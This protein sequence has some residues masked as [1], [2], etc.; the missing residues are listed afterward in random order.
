MSSSEAQSNDFDN[1][2]ESA[3]NDETYRSTSLRADE[4]ATSSADAVAAAPVQGD[5]RPLSLKNRC[6]WWNQIF[7][8]F[9][10][11]LLIIFTFFLYHKNKVDA[12]T[13]HMDV[14]TLTLMVLSILLGAILLLRS[15][16]GARFFHFNMSSRPVLVLLYLV[17]AIVLFTDAKHLPSWIMKLQFERKEVLPLCFLVFAAMEVLLFCFLRHCY[18]SELEDIQD[19]ENLS[20]YTSRAA[21]RSPWWW[22]GGGGRNHRRRDNSDNLEEPLLFGQPSWTNRTSN[23]YQVRD[24][25]NA[26]SSSSSWWPFSRGVSGQNARDDG[27]VDYA[28]LNEDWASRSEADPTWWSR[29]DDGH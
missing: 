3:A 27:S 12:S 23:N 8:G 28:S 16:I 18:A 6:I 4:R 9:F 11:A 21:G 19:A 29:D 20:R 26:S 25:V 10:S 13:T 24:G 5:P 17:T 15:V 2:W 14:V 7:D 1:P 22:S